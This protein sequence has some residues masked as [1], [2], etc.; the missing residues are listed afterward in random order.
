MNNQDFLNM[1]Y[2]ARSAI[3]K[4]IDNKSMQVLLGICSGIIADQQLNDVEIH[5]LQTWLRDHETICD[6]W[7]AS[8][9]HYKIEQILQDGIITAEE[10]QQTL[11]LLQE[12]TGNYFMETG[13]AMPESPALPIEKDPKIEFVNKSFCF[14]GE[15]LFGTRATCE[16]AVLK[17][18]AMPLDR[19]TKKLDFL[20]IGA[21][22][23]PAWSNET[24]GRKIEKAIE[25]RQTIG[26]P[27]IISEKQWT[28]TL[29][30]Y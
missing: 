10:R 27:Y 15:F 24:Y 28:E 6:K 30:K 12:I 3:S 9:I 14:T 20:V 29:I 19:V 21:Y 18:G 23:S 4:N 5:Y 11:S 7:P 26:R 17:L 2:S 22:C 25:T 13:A 16:R 8:G 1:S